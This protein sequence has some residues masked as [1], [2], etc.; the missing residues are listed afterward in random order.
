MEESPKMTDLD[1]TVVTTVT[2]ATV[3]IGR[4]GRGSG[5]VIA[6]GFVL[7]NAHNLRDRSTQVGFADGRHAQGT[8]AGTDADGD[9]AVLAVETGDAAPL[10]WA[11][12]PPRVGQTLVAGAAGGLHHR[13][14][15]G[16]VS[17]VGQAFRSGGGRLVQD[18]IEHTVPLA[19]GSSGGPLVD[20]AGRLVGI[21]THRIGHRFYLAR[22]GDDALRSRI[23]QLRAGQSVRP[24]RLGVALAPND[25][26]RGLRR[27]VG[28]PERDGLLVRGVADGSPASAAGI[29]EGDLL[30]SVGGHTVTSIDDLARAVDTAATAAT[31]DAN[32]MAIGLVRGADELTV[33]VR[34]DEPVADSSTPQ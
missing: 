4:D 29:R 34:F 15:V 28:L 32:T 18:A 12:S 22:R 17:A 16:H 11:E 3:S 27:A 6:P 31:A 13:V 7:T 26:A 20:L 23:E 19:R 5:V 9:L 25:I 24:R 33:E 1:T 21:N 10:D 30:V 2:A 8:V 14:T